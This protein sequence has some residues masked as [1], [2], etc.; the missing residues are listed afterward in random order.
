M[1]PCQIN[2][3]IGVRAGM[4]P[5]N[6]QKIYFFEYSFQSILAVLGGVADILFMGATDFGVSVL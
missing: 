2:Q 1:R 4:M 6:I 3:S 5:D